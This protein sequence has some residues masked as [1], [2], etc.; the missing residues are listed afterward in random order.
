MRWILLMLLTG[1]VG[2]YAGRVS[3]LVCRADGEVT[4]SARART[5]TWTARDG[6]WRASGSGQSYQPS[7]GESCAASVESNI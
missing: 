1:C 3:V 2:E 4:F 5:G 6:V 7:P